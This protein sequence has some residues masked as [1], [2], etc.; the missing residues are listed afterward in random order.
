M[1]CARAWVVGITV[2]CTLA[3]CSKSSESSKPSPASSTKPSAGAC[4]TLDQQ[5][6]DAAKEPVDL[7]GLD[8]TGIDSS[9]RRREQ[10]LRSLAR[11]DG[12]GAPAYRTLADLIARARPL[13]VQRWGP[14]DG[15][16]LHGRT[17]ASKTFRVLP[18]ALSE[19]GK[20]SESRAFSRAS[21]DA[22]WA[23]FR[24]A[25]RCH[26]VARIPARDPSRLTADGRPPL[27]LL[28][29]DLAVGGRLVRVGAHADV[30]DLGAKD[31]RVHDPALSPDGT[32]IAAETVTAAGQAPRIRTIS[33]DGEVREEFA[34]GWDCGGWL[35]D[36]TLVLGAYQGEGM[37]FESGQAGRTLR[38]EGGSCPTPGLL[39]DEV[40]VTS[41]RTERDPTWVAAERAED[42][43]EV[44]RYTLPHC[45][46]TSPSAS[47]AASLVALAVGCDD[48]LEDGIWI[49]GAS[50]RMTHSLT[51][52]CGVPTFSPDGRWLSYVIAPT[53]GTGGLDTR[54]GF[55]HPDGSEAFHLARGRLS[56][57]LWPPASGRSPAGPQ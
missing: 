45:T 27:P 26:D 40:L 43:S 9:L 35:P 25:A 31:L 53:D 52:V 47:P 46:V 56:F 41:G 32:A 18:Q 8:Q 6:A 24:L 7:I 13:V 51:C 33:I 17:L 2:A 29:L 36:G 39:P 14:R 34:A 11:A 15:T 3:A 21:S 16:E 10:R 22:S 55:A 50:G 38:L 44:R 1:T 23:R 4:R 12:E 19:A 54:L 49:V 48:P 37:R 57:P 28:A 30:A 42:G 20:K 5:V